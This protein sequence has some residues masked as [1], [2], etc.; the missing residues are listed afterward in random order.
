MEFDSILPFRTALCGLLLAMIVAR[1]AG[2]DLSQMYCS[3][4]NTGSDHSSGEYGYGNYGYP[5]SLTKRDTGSNIYQSAGSCSESCRGGSYAF[6]VVQYSSCW[7]TNYAPYDQQDTGSCNQ[8]C[9]GYP[10][11]LCG[12][13]NDGLYGYLPLG[14][15]ASGT[16]GAPSSTQAPTSSTVSIAHIPIRT[17]MLRQSL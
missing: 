11:N 2:S 14:N 6:A 3:N 4:Q 10:D 17:L 16:L 7:C 12:N 13:A 5:P 1:V 8:P 9:P 15:A